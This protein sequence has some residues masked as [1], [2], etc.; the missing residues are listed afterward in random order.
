M[1][2]A[3]LFAKLGLQFDRA[4]FAKAK[5]GIDKITAAAKTMDNA[6]SKAA[7]N[8][9]AAA[10]AFATINPKPFKSFQSFASMAFAAPEKKAKGFFETVR[11]GIQRVR[12]G[13]IKKRWNAGTTE[14]TDTPEKSSG[15]GGMILGAASVAAA[16]K[17]VSVMKDLALSATAYADSLA[18]LSRKTNVSTKFLQELGYAAGGGAEG[19]AV[20]QQSITKFG[21]Q[22]EE[23][24][25]NKSSESAQAFKSLGI[26]LGSFE[27]QSGDVAAVM[28]QVADKFATMRDGAEKNALGIKL[29]GKSGSDL[30]VI[31]S[32]LKDKQA[33]FA[34]AG[35]G[36]SDEQI[37][38]LSALNAQV[39]ILKQGYENLKLRAGAAIAVFASETIDAAKNSKVLQEILATVKEAYNDIKTAVTEAFADPAFKEALQAIGVVLGVVFVIAK[40][41]FQFFIWQIKWAIKLSKN[42]ADVFVAV[43]KA[44]GTAI[45]WAVTQIIW[46][47]EK[48]KSIGS[49]ISDFFSSIGDAV[50]TI[51][52]V[53][54]N[55]VR[56][57]Y[58]KLIKWVEEKIAWAGAQVA[59]VKGFFSDVG[60]VFSGGPANAQDAQRNLAKAEARLKETEL[61]K[62][63]D[64]QSVSQN[65][66]G[67]VINV[68]VNGADP[69]NADMIARK[70]KEASDA[71]L[72][73]AAAALGFTQ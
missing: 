8:T 35:G 19:L 25:G 41:L 22:L 58:D 53:P 16:V 24:M 46:L 26:D 45:A 37:K 10:K 4:S 57:E 50:K 38:K 27:A 18:D 13:D 47:W 67:G 5:D 7:K 59:K 1:I 3:E 36:M 61:R 29:F 39:N 9:S 71:S 66:N 15:L 11:R 54:I 62:S 44:I 30:A 72:R 65:V 51:I 60:D 52:M 34:K 28:Q 14:P 21:L 40:K 23:S 42:F 70:V 49:A 17:T 20:A 55:F 73:N 68:N 48:L 31:L 2:I 43:G 69:N 64:T 12:F 33:D 6:V 32:Q 56:D 63:R